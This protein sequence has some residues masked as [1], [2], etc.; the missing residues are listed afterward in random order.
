MLASRQKTIR[1]NAMGDDRC[2]RD[3]VPLHLRREL[4]DVA[5][6]PPSRNRV[7]IVEIAYTDEANEVLSYLR[8][9]VAKGEMSERALAVTGQVRHLLGH[10]SLS[11]TLLRRSRFL[12]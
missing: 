6:I 12:G 7:P 2:V 5:P 8:A 11:K 1:V 4:L 9:F 3:W 10:S